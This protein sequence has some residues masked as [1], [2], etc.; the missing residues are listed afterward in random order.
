[1]S[2]VLEIGGM[3]IEYRVRFSERAK[4]KRIIVTPGSVEVVAPADAAMDGSG[5]VLE[6]VQRKRRWVFDAV[7]EIET[8]HRKLLTQHYD[9]GAKLQYRGRWL[10]LDVQAADVEAVEISCKSKLHVRVPVGLEGDGRLVAV[11]DAFEV[12]LKERALK[13]LGRFV[14]LHERGVGVKAEGFRLSDAKR[15]WGT[16]GRDGVIR[17]HWRLIQ[18]P[19]AAM[20]YVAAHEVVHLVHRNHGPEF[21]RVLGMT[22]PDWAERKVMLERWEGEHRAV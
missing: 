5:G 15:S 2:G 9:S 17:L 4:R 11:R 19:A 13:D 14:R 3:A 8:K 18:A 7:Q 1:M 20:E 12:W 22:M 16:L 6:Y 21:W 10:M